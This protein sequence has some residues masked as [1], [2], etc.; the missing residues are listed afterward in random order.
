MT[1]FLLKVAALLLLAYLLALAVAGVPAA[2]ASTPHTMVLSARQHVTLAALARGYDDKQLGCLLRLVNRE[3]R[4]NPAAQNKKSTASGL[5]QQLRSPSG[6]IAR[7][8][9]PAEQ[10]RRGLDY[11]QARYGSAT[12]PG[13]CTALRSNLKRGWY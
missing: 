5:F 7:T 9:T 4:F 6:V 2:K 3:S 13:A 12:N 8:L 11:I 1:L 10:T